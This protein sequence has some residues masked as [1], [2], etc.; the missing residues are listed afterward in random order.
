VFIQAYTLGKIV[1]DM[2]S[3]QVNQEN[4]NSLINKIIKEVFIKQ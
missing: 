2:S 4:Y 1:D 3:S